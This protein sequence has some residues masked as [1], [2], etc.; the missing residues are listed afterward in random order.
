M[1]SFSTQRPDRRYALL[2][3]ALVCATAP[4]AAQEFVADLQDNAR[5]LLYAKKTLGDTRSAGPAFGLRVEQPWR[6]ERLRPQGG[7]LAA[8]T[9]VP[10]VDLA[11]DGRQRYALQ[12][13]D[14]PVL[15]RFAPGLLDRRERFT[16][17]PRR[18]EPATPAP[19]AL[20]DWPCR[21]A[22]IR[23]RSTVSF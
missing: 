9:F 2:L 14:R 13:L 20:D 5:F 8:I 18:S 19:C 6:R 12:L 7:D 10:V 1:P 23:G 21:F 15:D 16:L 3:L 11:V 22:G 17:R 4:A